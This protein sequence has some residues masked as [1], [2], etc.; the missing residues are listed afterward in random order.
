MAIHKVPPTKTILLD[1]QKQLSLAEEGYNLLDRKREVLLNELMR[2]I[3]RLKEVQKNAYADF[4]I[5]LENFKSAYF[6]MSQ[7][8]IRDVLDF[9]PQKPKI[10]TTYRS[11]MGIAVPEIVQSETYPQKKPSLDDSIAD[12]EEVHQKMRQSVLNLIEYANIYNAIMKLAAEINKTRKRVNALENIFI[13]DY[14]DTINWVKDAI[15]ENEREE[16]FRQKTV[17]KRV[18]RNA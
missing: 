18:R 14:N 11:V 9:E 15:E 2:Y 10:T 16:F 1:Y 17:K 8:Q 6:K 12:I 13:P 3:H 7:E 4:V 5:S